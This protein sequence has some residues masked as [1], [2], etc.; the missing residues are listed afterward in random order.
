MVR[1]TLFVLLCCLM[2]LV[3]V[4]I[5][6]ADGGAPEENETTSGGATSSEGQTS[7]VASAQSVNNPFLFV[8]VPADHWAVEDLK[9]L[10]EYGVITG[11]PNGAYN[12]DSYLTRYSAA[13][14]QARA[15]RLLMNHPDLVSQSDLDALQEL[16]FQTSERLETLTEQVQALDPT[17]TTESG[18]SMTQRLSE[19]QAQLATLR[20]EFDQL[21]NNSP[22]LGGEQIAKLKESANVNFIIAI[23]SLFVGV[24]G[25]ALAI[26]T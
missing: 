2:L 19:N 24:L 4:P 10:V 17:L 16:I 15:L 6:Y 5:G 23:A 3:V 18:A 20:L 22:Q 9:F 1:G 14:M 26:M 25:I 11:L 8:D 12:G 21:K 13:A 7:N